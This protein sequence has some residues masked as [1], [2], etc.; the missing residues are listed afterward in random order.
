M[1]TVTMSYE[2]LDRVSVVE[3]VIAKRLTQR[4]AGRMLGLTSRQVRRLCQAYG[5]DGPVGLASK[6]RGR[7]SNRRLSSTLRRDA[8]YTVRSRY[9]GFGPTLAHEKLTELHGLEL[10]VETLR[11]WMI[12]DGLWTPR[13]RREPRIQQPRRR[14]PCRGEL[15]QIDGSDHEWFEERAPRCTLLVFVDDATS[16][17]ME[18]LFCESESAFSY[19]TALRSYLDQHGKPVALY[20]DKAG[21]FRVNRKKPQGGTGV[22]QFGRALTSLN[23]DILCANTPAAKGRVERAHLTLQ[24]RLVKELRLREISDVDAANA[25]APEFIEDYNRRFARAPR[26]EHDAHRPLQRSEDLARVFSWQETRL[27]SKS[28][29]LNYKRVLYVLDPTDAARAARGKPVGIEE[30]EDGSLSFWHGE[31]PLQAT[32]FP[33][34]HA[35]RQG[36]V[37]DNKRLSA[38]LEFI[39]EQQRE[40]TEKKIAKPSTTRREARLLRAGTPRRHEAGSEVVTPP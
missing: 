28:L 23:I 39:K 29:T 36:D 5:R 10:S 3:R 20:S 25:F 38:A 11:H 8:L 18:L 15:I 12:E 35:V 26:S 27:V 33:K 37:V 21:V 30:R 13:A 40:R 9:E 7:P 17:L 2:E 32:A 19:F 16:A 22:T 14:R 4:E 24:D 6:H 34:D 1:E 31:R